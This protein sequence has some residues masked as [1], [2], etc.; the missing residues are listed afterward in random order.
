MDKQ[1]EDGGLDGPNPPDVTI[2]ATGATISQEWSFAPTKSTDGELCNCFIPFNF[3]LFAP[4][5]RLDAILLTA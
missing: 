1:N 4:A 2:N 3:L 5:W